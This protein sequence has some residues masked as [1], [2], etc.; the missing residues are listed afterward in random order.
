MLPARDQYV[1]TTSEFDSVRERLRG[2]ENRNKL[3]DNKNN[4]GRPTLRTRTERQTPQ[5]GQSGQQPS[6]QGGDPSDDSDRPT[7]KRRTDDDPNNSDPT[8]QP[9]QTSQPIRAIRE[10][11]D[12][13]TEE[14]ADHRRSAFLFMVRHDLFHYNLDL[15]GGLYEHSFD[16]N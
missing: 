4:Q 1:V 2:I 5:A 12:H 13:K 3:I 15:S 7:L 9:S 14:K 16:T 11:H 6:A 10:I 8:S